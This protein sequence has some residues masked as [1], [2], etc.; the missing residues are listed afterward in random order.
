MSSDDATRPP[1]ATRPPLK[2]IS[3]RSRT[4]DVEARRDRSQSVKRKSTFDLSSEKAKSLKDSSNLSQDSLPGR[5]EFSESE[6][7]QSV[8]VSDQ[9]E[10]N[11]VTLG[12]TDMSQSL[13][14]PDQI[15]KT[16]EK[17]DS[18][19]DWGLDLAYLEKPSFNL[20]DS[21][22]LFALIKEF[23]DEQRRQGSNP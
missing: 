11:A 9:I 15:A 23:D 17:V 8:I 14:V 2:A 16:S 12:R 13:I 22:D 5:F 3:N 7:A 6:M 19:S 4:V 1:Y 10:L 20:S 21:E 18:T